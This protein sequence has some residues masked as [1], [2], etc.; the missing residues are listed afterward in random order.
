MRVADVTVR[1]KY[2]YEIPDRHG[3]RRVY[4]WRGKGHPRVRIL[5]TPGSAE[6]WNRYAELR[7]AVP[8]VATTRAPERTLGWLYGQWLRSAEFGQLR[9]ASQRSYRSLVNMALAETV[10]PGEPET[11]GDFPLDRLL[12]KHVR[13]LRDRKAGRPT[14]ANNRV[15]VL[16]YVFKWGIG[17]GY[18]TGNPAADVPKLKTKKAGYHT[19]TVGE[20]AQYEARHAV[21]TKARLALDLIVYTGARR[22]DVV[23][24]GRQ[25]V[26]NGWIRFTPEKTK[27][28]GTVVELPMSPELE[29]SIAAT[30]CGDLTFLVTHYGRPFTSQGFGH[31]FRERCDEADVPGSAHGIRKAA[32]TRAAE[33]GATPHQLMAMFGWLN[34]A[35]ADRYTKAAQRKT[36]ASNAVVLMKRDI[37]GT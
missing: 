16:G 27:G 21:G 12:A 5:E 2:L 8:A 4:F 29:A 31:Y 26:R 13:I 10:A 23:R 15:M 36:L 37:Q 19:W 1:A 22:S 28:H 20:L 18:V 7:D 3:N 32:A 9:P 11:Y 6:Y 14:S 24:L 33:N 35:E 30:P 34:L 17:A 25:H